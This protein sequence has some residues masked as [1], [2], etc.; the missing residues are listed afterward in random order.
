MDEQEY[1]ER[2]ARDIASWRRDGILD[3]AAEAALLA[4]VGIEPTA[5]TRV[6]RLGWFASI[7]SI[8]GAIVLAAGVVLLFGA[9]WEEL[10]TWFRAGSLIAGMIVAYAAGYVLMERYGMQRIG[11]AL[12]LL[13]ALLFEAA[14]FLLAQIYNMPVDSPELWLLAALGTFP[15]AYLFGS[16][17]ILLLAIANVIAY[18]VSK[19]LS[20][21]GDSPKSETA[22]LV[23]AMLG[24][25][26]YAG[27][28]L[29]AL[30]R[31]L[32]HFAETYVLL[33]LLVLLGLIYM[34]SFDEPWSSMIDSGVRSFSAPP[35]VYV[36]MAAALAVVA[37]QFAL[38]PRSVES[39][40]ESAGQVVIIGIA[41]IVATWPGWTG[42]ALI[43]NAVYFA[44][45]F[46]LVAR[47]Y[48]LQDERYINIGLAAIA[49]GLATRYIDV[50]WSLLATSAFFI[51]GGV[52]LLAVAFALEW[53]RR[54]L[55]RGMIASRPGASG[56]NA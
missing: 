9:S 18:T 39:A 31:L 27:G 14:I 2:L 7:V 15:L 51:I 22:L 30:H 17:I 34:F 56:G 38:R 53:T 45:G 26:L 46:G 44:I 36:S 4:R 28:R 12:L 23:V 50:F 55:V 16:R 48:L 52:L 35:V 47:G 25:V 32:Q 24:V 10:A 20:V 3:P 29:H 40:I 33:G 54:G 42:Y 21:Y 37:A 11:S 1:R 43:F 13:G 6:L 49:L 8:I 5:A 19:V 41:G